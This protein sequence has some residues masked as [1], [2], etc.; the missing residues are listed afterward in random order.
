MV[1]PSGR[2]WDAECAPVAKT[3]SHGRREGKT[4]GYEVPLGRSAAAEFAIQSSAG[5]ATKIEL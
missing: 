1:G 3:T 4:V 5:E 2:P